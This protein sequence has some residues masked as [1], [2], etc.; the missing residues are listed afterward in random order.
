MAQQ[1]IQQIAIDSIIYDRSENIRDEATGAYEVSSLRNDL[2]L[3]GQTEPVMLERRKNGE[4]HILRGFRRI[5]AMLE[6]NA[7]SDED[8]A[9]LGFDVRRFE[10]V[11]AIVLDD[12]TPRDREKYRID[13][14]Q[15]RN[16][17]RV[18]LFFAVERAFS[19]G[20]TEK[21]VVT[22]LYDLFV[23]HYPPK[24]TIEDTDTA[25]L[26]Y[27]RGVVQNL[28]LAWDSPTVLREAFVKKERG[29]QRWP[30]NAEL[31][32]YHKI[33][34][35]ERDSDKTN[36][37]NRQN[38]GPE[39][40]REWAKYTQVKKETAAEGGRGKAMS[41]MN[42]NQVKDAKKSV[43]SRI[44]KYVLD[45]VVRDLPSDALPELDALMVEIEKNLTDEQNRVL[46]SLVDVTA[47]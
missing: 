12:L 24:K 16:L 30:T 25:K 15:R 38:P 3:N 29:E 28:K 18:E 10:K 7:M 8:F 41:M 42:G 6:A 21:E 17:N 4:L 27:Y 14:S 5:T 19:V 22:T 2:I 44:I 40:L 46:D 9:K 11:D 36:K 43:N 45:I 31:R 37:I 39:F 23:T 20:W 34:A 35:T 26:E 47:G 13:Q 1:K 33:F 32:K